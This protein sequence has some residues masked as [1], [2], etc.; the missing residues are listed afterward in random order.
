MT[1]RPAPLTAILLALPLAA[2][3]HGPATRFLTI[4]AAPPPAAAVRAGYR[5]PPVTIP[6][7]HVPAALDRVEYARE[8]AA[9]QVTVSDFDRWAAPL[10]TLMRDALARDLAARLP[11]GAVLTPGLAVPA[12]GALRV[13]VVVTGFDGA[14]GTMQAAYQLLPPGGHAGTR[15]EALLTTSAAGADPG[16]AAR[17]LAALLGQL[18]DRIAAD[19]P[20]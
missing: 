14:A 12:G 11:E 10:G 8:A 18:A 15:H 6:A 2:C 4:D 13:D 20:G 16:A 9:G 5:G 7:V 3:G 17:T 1:R 19:L